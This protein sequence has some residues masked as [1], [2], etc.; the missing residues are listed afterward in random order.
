MVELTR[1]VLLQPTQES[2]TLSA[3]TREVP[4]QKR[5]VLV[6]DTTPLLT[7]PRQ[8][9]H[10]TSTPETT[11]PDEMPQ[12]YPTRFGA[13]LAECMNARG[14]SEVVLAGL[15]GVSDSTIDKA[16]RGIRIPNAIVTADICGVLRIPDGHPLMNDLLLAASLDRIDRYRAFKGFIPVDT[17]TF[18][19]YSELLFS[20]GTH[21]RDMINT[22]R[23][24]R[25]FS[26]EQ[27]AMLADIPRAVI[28]KTQGTTPSDVSIATLCGVL[29]IPDDHTVMLT[30]LLTA[31]RNRIERHRAQEGF[32]PVK[33]ETLQKY[34]ERVNRLEP[35]IALIISSFRGISGFTQEQLAMLADVSKSEIDKLENGVRMPG[36]ITIAK[37]LRA[38][39]IPDSDPLV[40][41]L[42]LVANYDRIKKDREERLN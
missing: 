30:L 16:K 35:K 17:K 29:G 6:T 14:I 37:I 22:L 24:I 40:N 11:L 19:Q 27:L 25:G 10:V 34:R 9:R 33:E 42:L 2:T 3:T 26:Q 7:L 12:T 15:S 21:V 4:S 32:K 1:R 36:D 39:G 18:Q 20:D 23:R 41:T 13:K 38:L 5:R 31:D 28:I 8:R